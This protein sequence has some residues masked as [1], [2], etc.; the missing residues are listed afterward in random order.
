MAV[1]APIAPVLT[2]TAAPAGLL[3]YIF[4]A[5]ITV[6]IVTL[7]GRVLRTRYSYDEYVYQTLAILLL[8]IFTVEYL[9]T[10]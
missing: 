9:Y 3:Q 10:A 7:M 8:I 4:T 5:G 2:Y 1:L 6:G